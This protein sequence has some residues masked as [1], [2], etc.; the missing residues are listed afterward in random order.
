[1]EITQIEAILAS[2]SLLSI[3]KGTLILV[4]LAVCAVIISRYCVCCMDALSKICSKQE[5]NGKEDIALQTR[6]H[7]LDLS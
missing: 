7:V 6:Q 3:F 4:A 2:I 5:A 1:M